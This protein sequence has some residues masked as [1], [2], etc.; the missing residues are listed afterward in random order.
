[1]QKKEERAYKRDQ[2]RKG[3]PG[4]EKPKIM[5]FKKK[6][7]PGGLRKTEAKDVHRTAITIGGR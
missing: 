5:L 4:K 3:T 1:M 7:T 6:A 2:L